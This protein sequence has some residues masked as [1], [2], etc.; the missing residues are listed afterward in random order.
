M[1]SVRVRAF[2]RNVALTHLDFQQPLV[3]LFLQTALASLKLVAKYKFSHETKNL[4]G[5]NAEQA[6][7][8][9][10]EYDVRIKELLLTD[11]VP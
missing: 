6:V 4:K 2:A 1:N 9:I 5:Y 10:T 8:V 11:R 7:K 3:S